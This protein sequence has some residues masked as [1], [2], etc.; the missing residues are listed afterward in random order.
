MENI[1]QKKKSCEEKMFIRPKLASEYAVK[2]QQ[3]I[4]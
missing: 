3:E 4:F 2:K 1:K